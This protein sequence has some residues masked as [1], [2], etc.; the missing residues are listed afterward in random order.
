VQIAGL[1]LWLRAHRSYAELGLKPAERPALTKANLVCAG[2][3]S[4][5]CIL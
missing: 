1:S 3:P 2:I 5:N 4:V